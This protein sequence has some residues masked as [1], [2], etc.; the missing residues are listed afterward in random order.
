MA[1][2]STLLSDGLTFVLLVN[3]ILGVHKD[4]LYFNYSSCDIKY[5]EGLQSLNWAK[6]MKTIM[7][8]PAGFFE[9]GG[10]GFLEPDSDVRMITNGYISS[11]IK[12]Q[13]LFEGGERL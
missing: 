1:K 3:F 10:W 2:V 6:I 9:T 8:D 5:T 13:L 7:D 4:L 11:P 12:Y